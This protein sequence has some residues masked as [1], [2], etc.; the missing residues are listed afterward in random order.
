[1]CQFLLAISLGGTGRV[2]F[3]SPI[4]LGTLTAAVL[5]DLFPDFVPKRI[6]TYSKPKWCR[7]LGE[8]DSRSCATFELQTGCGD[9][10]RADSALMPNTLAV[11]LR[12]CWESQLSTLAP[13]LGLQPSKIA[14]KP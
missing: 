11:R 1:M 7:V 12:R 8:M 4:F 13:K 10:G 6:Q 5:G 2:E 14:G 3:L 9:A